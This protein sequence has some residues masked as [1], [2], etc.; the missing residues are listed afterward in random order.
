MQDD[1][2]LLKTHFRA[3]LGL[4]MMIILLSQLAS[5]A[6]I[7]LAYKESNIQQPVIQNFFSP[8]DFYTSKDGWRVAFGLSAFD[9]WANTEKFDESYG[10]IHAYKASWSIDADGNPSPYEY[11]ELETEPCKTSDINYDHDED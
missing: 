3:I 11:E 9:E 4:I 2:P 7:M 6:E 8:R 1:K 10:S 5:K